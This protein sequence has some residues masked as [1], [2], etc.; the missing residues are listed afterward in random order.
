MET[1]DIPVWWSGPGRYWMTNGVHER[2]LGYCGSVEELVARVMK[3]VTDGFDLGGATILRPRSKPRAQMTHEEW[4][5][6]HLP[7]LLVDE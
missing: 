2:H 3:E 7:D 4:L 5:A 1:F 6:S